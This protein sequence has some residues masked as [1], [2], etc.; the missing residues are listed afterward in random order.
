MTREEMEKLRDAINKVIMSAGKPLDFETIFSGLQ[1]DGVTLPP[2]KPKLYVRRVLYEKDWF[3]VGKG[4]V[5]APKGAFPELMKTT[6]LS[7]RPGIP[8]ISSILAKHPVHEKPQVP[9]PPAEQPAVVK[10]AGE[11]SSKVEA[12]SPYPLLQTIQE[13]VEKGKKSIDTEAHEAAKRAVKEAIEDVRKSVVHLAR[14]AVT[15]A[16]KE[17]IAQTIHNASSE[18]CNAIA[19]ESRL[20]VDK[21]TQETIEKLKAIADDITGKTLSTIEKQTLAIIQAAEKRMHYSVESAPEPQTPRAESTGSIR[22]RITV[23]IAK[24]RRP[25]TFEEIY[26]ALETDGYQMPPRNPQE[27]IR[28]VLENPELF[29]KDGNNRYI[30]L[31]FLRQSF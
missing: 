27:V 26:A 11:I 28:R 4:G 22:E 2:E 1:R 8:G 20:I 7:P 3:E 14:E 16:L 17:A 9:L 12:I 6:S 24:A 29:T 31:D 15:S 5:F 21:I 19:R 13:A 25:L 30:P 23:A 10:P 18:A